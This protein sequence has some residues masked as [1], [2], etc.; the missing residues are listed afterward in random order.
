MSAQRIGHI[1]AILFSAFMLFT[2]VGKFTGHPEISG[3]LESGNMGGWRIIIGIGQAIT[4][5]LFAIPLT[6]RL[7]MFLFA[8]YWGGAI[9]FHMAHPDPSE[10][11]FTS[12]AIFLVLVFITS[13]LR[14]KDL[15]FITK[16]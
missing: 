12:A 1:V 15:F 10:Q 2:S 7:G 3:L 6:R 11:G 14:E 13:W 8:A 5:I 9:V 16:D 4:A